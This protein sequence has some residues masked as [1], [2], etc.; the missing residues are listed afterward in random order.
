M[1]CIIRAFLAARQSLRQLKEQLFV[2]L[3]F[4]L[5]SPML[6]AFP[7]LAAGRRGKYFAERP[8]I[9]EGHFWRALGQNSWLLVENQKNHDDFKKNNDKKCDRK[10]LHL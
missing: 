9:C 1:N 7:Y 8:S 10:D 5:L 2:K 3:C 6:P 4:V